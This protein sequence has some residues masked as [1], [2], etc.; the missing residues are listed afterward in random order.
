[1]RMDSNSTWLDRTP[2][3]SLGLLKF[4]LNGPGMEA[5]EQKEVIIFYSLRS[6]NEMIVKRKSGCRLHRMFPHMRIVITH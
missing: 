1:M 5:D 2:S 6:E 3:D 4:Y